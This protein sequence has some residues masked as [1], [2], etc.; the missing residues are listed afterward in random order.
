MKKDMLS[1]PVVVSLVF[2]S[3]FATATTYSATTAQD[4]A[5]T[6]GEFEPHKMLMANEVARQLTNNLI[7][8]TPMSL[9]STWYNGQNL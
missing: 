5:I 1:L 4:D 9:V 6:R 8:A 7:A 3:I 2:V